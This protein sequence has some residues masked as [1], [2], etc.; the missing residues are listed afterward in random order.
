MSAI[1][2]RNEIRDLSSHYASIAD[3]RDFEKLRDIFIPEGTLGAYFGDPATVEPLFKA[4]G[5]DNIIQAFG[6]LHRYES[7]FHC[8]GQ[9]LIQ[10]IAATTARSETYCI[11]RH[12][13][14]KR[15]ESQCVVWYIRYDDY[16]VKQSGAWKLKTRT[17][18]VDRSEGEDV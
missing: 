18:I 6:A 11:A 5:V 14:T 17:I 3:R 8:I 9:Q 4:N 10:E 1:E 13:H 2:D 16:L 15:G 12:W 7:T